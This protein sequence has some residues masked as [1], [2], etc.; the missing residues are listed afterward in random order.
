MSLS[1]MGRAG[2]KCC[3]RRAEADMFFI[4]RILHYHQNHVRRFTAGCFAK[5]ML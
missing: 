1:P 2:G 5:T 3:R 4:Y